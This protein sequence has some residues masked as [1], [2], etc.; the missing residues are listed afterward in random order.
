MVAHSTSFHHSIQC[1]E[2]YTTVSLY[3]D[4]G[5]FFKGLIFLL[6]WLQ[7]TKLHITAVKLPGQGKPVLCVQGRAVGEFSPHLLS[8]Y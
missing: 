5:L 4:I 6:Y 7:N 2:D 1:F 8:Y 3:L